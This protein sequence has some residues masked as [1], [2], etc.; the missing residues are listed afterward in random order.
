MVSQTNEQALESTIEKCLIGISTEELKEGLIPQFSS[1]GYVIGA[2]SD[3]NM[4]YAI[5]ERFFWQFIKKTQETELTK[6]QKNNPTDW[7]RKLLERFD[8]L[9]K[10]H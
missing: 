10:K 4:Q 3:F 8:R 7:Q 6:L 2:S 5:D 1:A 9:I